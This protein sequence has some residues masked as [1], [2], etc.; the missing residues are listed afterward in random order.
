MRVPTLKPCCLLIATSA[1]S[2]PKVSANSSTLA[3]RSFT[4]SSW[5]IMPFD[6]VMMEFMSLM[7]LMIDEILTN[8]AIYYFWIAEV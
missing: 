5:L 4:C 7:H 2:T 6:S 1:E 8:K 3:T